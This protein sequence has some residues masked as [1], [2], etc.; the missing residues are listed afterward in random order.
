[1][2][3]TLTP[4]VSISGKCLPPAGAKRG[5]TLLVFDRQGHTAGVYFGAP[6]NLHGE[7]ERKLASL[8]K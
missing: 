4:R 3:E 1:V 2:R 8:L 7:A 6:P 5:A